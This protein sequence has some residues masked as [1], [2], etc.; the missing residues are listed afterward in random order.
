MLREIWLAGGTRTGIGGF[1]GTLAEMSAPALGSVVIKEAIQRAGIGAERVDQVF[2]G[3]VVGAGLGQNVA[4]QASIGAGVPASVGAT[5][6]NKVCGSGLQAVMLASQVI[7]CGDAEVIVAGGTENMS[8]APYIL[9]KARAGYRLG[10]G[11]IVDAVVRDGL[12][13]VYNNLHMGTFGDRCATKLGITRQE[14]DDF[15]VASYQRAQKAQQEHLFAEEITTVEIPSRKGPVIVNQDE[16]PGRFNEQKL[17]ALRPAFDPNGSV[18][19]EHQ[20]RGCCRGGL[21]R[22]EGQGVRHH[23]AGQDTRLLELR[24][25]TGVV[26]LGARLR[27][28][29]T[30]EAAGAD[31]RRRGFVRG[32]RSVFGCAHG[33]DAAT[34]CP[35]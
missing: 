28:R 24:P 4:R 26:Y 14:Q 19:A 8:A 20:R 7:Q 5:T 18:T 27:D 31:G 29:E 35:A 11:E 21:F 1:L 30:Y 34:A 12:W 6:V 32:E 10:N 23:S 9:N 2:F 25:R 17:R 13:D 16:E 15:A 33:R 3:N 22:R